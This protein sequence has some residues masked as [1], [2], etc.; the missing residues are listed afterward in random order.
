MA[1]GSAVMMMVRLS[2][3]LHRLGLLWN[4][5]LSLLLEWRGEGHL[6]LLLGL[7]DRIKTLLFV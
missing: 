4:L 1:M 2:L 3:L 6:K 7:L 5:G